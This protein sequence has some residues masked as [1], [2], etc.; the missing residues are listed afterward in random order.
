MAI[1]ACGMYY[2]MKNGLLTIVESQRLDS[3]ARSPVHS[4]FAVL[5]QGLV[6]LRAYSCISFLKIEFENNVN[7]GANATF[8]NITATRWLG[9]RIDL[10]F[11]V[12]GTSTVAF[13]ILLKG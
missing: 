7:K 2:F 13:C 8:C 6:T 3:V 9:F 5:V 12:F 11:F 10:L 4:T 1:I